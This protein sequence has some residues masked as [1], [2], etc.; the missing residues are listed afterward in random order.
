MHDQSSFLNR[1][2]QV[3]H[4]KMKGSRTLIDEIPEQM[5]DNDLKEN[6]N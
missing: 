1:M 2:Y 3:E 4:K 5:T 6:K